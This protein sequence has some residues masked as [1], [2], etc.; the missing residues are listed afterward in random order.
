[1]KL[2]LLVIQDDGTLN[3]KIWNPRHYKFV[4][5]NTFAAFKPVRL[6]DVFMTLKTLKRQ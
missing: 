4:W 3:V 1:M 5:D 6:R 2:H